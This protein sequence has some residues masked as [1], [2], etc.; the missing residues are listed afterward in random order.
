MEFCWRK[1]EKIARWDHILRLF[2]IE[3]AEEDDYKLCKNLTNHHV[4]N[5]KKM[6]V[7]V[8]A[9]IF[10]NNVAAVLKRMALSSA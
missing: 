10:S 7:S 6:K 3:E 9:Q 4:H 8:A 1:K 5:T 2:E